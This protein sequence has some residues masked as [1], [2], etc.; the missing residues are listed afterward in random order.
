MA[1]QQSKY[2]LGTISD[3]FHVNWTNWPITATFAHYIADNG[4]MMFLDTKGLKNHFCHALCLSSVTYY[5][6]LQCF[7]FRFPSEA[8]PIEHKYG[9][10]NFFLFYL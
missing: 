2:N 7:S 9:K 1:D 8:S 6:V 4:V 5:A 3:K 10:L